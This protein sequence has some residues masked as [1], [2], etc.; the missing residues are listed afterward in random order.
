MHHVGDECAGN[1]RFD[2]SL[3]SVVEQRTSS[4]EGSARVREVVCQYLVFFWATT[5]RESFR[6]ANEQRTDALDHI[7]CSREIFRRVSHGS[8]R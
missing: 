7:C 6:R 2:A 5:L 1:R 8:Q 4:L 3:C